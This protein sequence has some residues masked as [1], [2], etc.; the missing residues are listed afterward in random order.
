M[1]RQE[2]TDGDECDIN[3][4]KNVIVENGS[5]GETIN[6]ATLPVPV[7][8]LDSDTEFYACDANDNN[9]LVFAGFAITNAVDGGAIQVQIT[10]IVSG[11]TGLTKGA[12]YYVSDTA[13]TISATAGTNSIAVGIAISA[14]E[15][16]ISPEFSS[17]ESTFVK[18][19]GD[20]TVAGVKTFSDIPVLPNSDPVSDNQLVRKAYVD[21][22]I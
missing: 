19:T 1:S 16:K 21:A 4:N 3:I 10:G 5:A 12:R 2:F 6:G 15:I 11:F 13:G 22:I 14:T 18:T 20:E 8:L 9:R 17:V 7:Y